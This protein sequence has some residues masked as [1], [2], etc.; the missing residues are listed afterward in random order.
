MLKVDARE[1][2]EWTN[3]AIFQYQS[4]LLWNE[5]GDVPESVYVH[6]LQ[7]RLIEAG[8]C[9]RL[10]ARYESM[11]GCMSRKEYSTKG[12]S[13]KVDLVYGESTCIKGLI[14]VK[15]VAPNDGISRIET[16]IARLEIASAHFKDNLLNFYLVVV[17]GAH[18]KSWTQNKIINSA[19]KIKNHVLGSSPQECIESLGAW[20]K[21]KNIEP[22]SRD[23]GW[24]TLA[25]DVGR[26]SKQR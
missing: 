25:L 2:G 23:H 8:Y 14:E 12:K 16:D 4:K 6:G 5:S 19:E 10:E 1:I 7:N 17:I 20:D 26:L 21:D 18:H 15:R 3:E 13:E 24:I 11:Y 22:P 9:V